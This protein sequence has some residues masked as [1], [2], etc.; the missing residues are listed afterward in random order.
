MRLIQYAKKTIPTLIRSH[1]D[2][3][4]DLFQDW[5]KSP[6]AFEMDRN[7]QNDLIIR[8]ANQQIKMALPYTEMAIN[9]QRPLIIDIFGKSKTAGLETIWLGSKIQKVYTAKGFKKYIQ[10]D[11]ASRILWLQGNAKCFDH[12]TDI[13]SDCS[14]LSWVWEITKNEMSSTPTLTV[15][16]MDADDDALFAQHVMT[17]CG[18]RLINEWLKVNGDGFEEIETV[19]W[20]AKFRALNEQMYVYD[21]FRNDKC[22]EVIQELSEK[23]FDDPLHTKIYN[24]VKNLIVGFTNGWDNR[25][26]TEHVVSRGNGR[27]NSRKNGGTGSSIRR[28]KYDPNAGSVIVSKTVQI[29]PTTDPNDEPKWKVTGH[30]RSATKSFQWLLERNVKQGE[31]VYGTNDRNGKT[32]CKVLRPR[33]SAIVNGGRG[34]E[35]TKGIIKSV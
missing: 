12:I 29:E 19:A 23:F 30:T 18:S 32:L 3:H 28:L 22:S 4:I 10:E 14:Y 25:Q 17:Q 24:E 27:K 1:N 20:Y 15:M 13:L 11:V 7:T 6:T 21:W 5:L 9:L 8:G 31:L 2:A 34:S 33:K 35:I 26:I 16:G